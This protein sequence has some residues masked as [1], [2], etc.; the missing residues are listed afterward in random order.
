M[1][2]AQFAGSTYLNLETYRRNGDAV[3]TP[4]W[5]AEDGGVFYIY[6]LADAGKI[7]R[8]RHNPHV[9]IAPCSFNGTLLGT[10]VE[11]TAR[12]LDGKAATRADELLDQ[13]YGWQRKLGNLWHR[14]VPKERSVVAIEPDPGPPS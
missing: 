1:T 14:I 3:R 10:W 9:R 5:F 7:K 2:L 11:V 8:I 4:V 6:S 13:K 12:I